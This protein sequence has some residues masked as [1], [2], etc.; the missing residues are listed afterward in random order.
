MVCYRRKERR[1][2]GKKGRREG[3]RRNYFSKPIEGLQSLGKK[4]TEDM[5]SSIF[6]SS[7]LMS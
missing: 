4:Q 5:K 3:R 6:L 1:K 7:L 2:T